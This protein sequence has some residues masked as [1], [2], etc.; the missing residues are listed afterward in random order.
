LE[1]GKAPAH[2]DGQVTPHYTTSLTATAEDHPYIVMSAP[3][4][5]PS[6]AGTGHSDTLSAV[7]LAIAA[8]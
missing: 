7:G 3:L 2:N 6:V 4:R 8:V 1:F 5:H